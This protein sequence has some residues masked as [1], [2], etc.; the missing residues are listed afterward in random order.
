LSKSRILPDEVL[1][2]YIAKIMNNL[3]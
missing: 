2:T 3:G 1:R